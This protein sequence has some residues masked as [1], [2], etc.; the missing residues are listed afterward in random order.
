M[1]SLDSG[2]LDSPFASTAIC[3]HKHRWLITELPG[4]EHTHLAWS[5]EGDDQRGDT[6]GVNSTRMPARLNHVLKLQ[7][8]SQGVER[9]H[10]YKRRRLDA[11]RNPEQDE[12]DAHR[13]THTVT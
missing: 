4:L 5:N 7:G 6:E 9:Q 3:K 11:K 1:S 10:A 2:L 13:L 8:G 12:G